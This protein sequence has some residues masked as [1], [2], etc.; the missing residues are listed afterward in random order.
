MATTTP[1]PFRDY[2]ANA[3][4][5]LQTGA[6]FSEKI[7][8]IITNYEITL[9]DYDKADCDVDD[10]YYGGRLEAL[11]EALSGLLN[12]PLEAWAANRNA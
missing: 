10:A 2:V 6:A 4:E 5:H 11:E 9:G 12:V 3:V 8:E 1:F 7:E